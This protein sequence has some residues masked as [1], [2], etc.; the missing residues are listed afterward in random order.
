ML[1]NVHMVIKKI[2]A[3]FTLL[4][5][6][7]ITLLIVFTA[8]LTAFILIA[9]NVFANGKTAFDS[10]VFS[11]LSLHVNNVNN[12]VMG[13]F[14]FLGTHLFLIAANIGLKI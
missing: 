5:M 6:E 10:R 14:S 7:I 13:F 12:N 9:K 1:G 11:F 4:S 8:S 3:G 2:V